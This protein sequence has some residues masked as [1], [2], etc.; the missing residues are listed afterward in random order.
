MEVGIGSIRLVSGG[1]NRAFAIRGGTCLLGIRPASLKIARVTVDAWIPRRGGDVA[2]VPIRLCSCIWLLWVV[3]AS[4][5]DFIGRAD[6]GFRGHEDFGGL[7]R[8][9]GIAYDWHWFGRWLTEIAELLS[10]LE[11]ILSCSSID[12]NCTKND[13]PGQI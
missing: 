2:N 13:N 9:E 4:E 10:L 8:A 3:E 6:G 7:N 11:D 1:G 12:G 5:I